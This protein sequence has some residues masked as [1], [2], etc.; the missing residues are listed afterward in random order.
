MD[1]VPAWGG[2]Y[3]FATNGGSRLFQCLPGNGKT[4]VFDATNKLNDLAQCC[5]MS[6]ACKQTFS[7]ARQCAQTGCINRCM[8]RRARNYMGCLI[9]Q[10]NANPPVCQFASLCVGQLTGNDS[11]DFAKT[12]AQDTNAVTAASCDPMDGF[13]DGLCDISNSCCP[14]CNT[15]MLRL[16][17]CLV[18]DFLLPASTTGGSVTCDLAL[19]FGQ[20]CQISGASGT[21]V[22]R[23]SGTFEETET[24]ETY[25][26]VEGVDISDCEEDLT[27]D[28]IVHNETYAADG[29][30]SCIGKKVGQVLSEAEGEN[31]DNPE[32]TSA[33]NSATF[34]LLCSVMVASSLWSMLA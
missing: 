26:D 28:F 13:V 34:V 24:E 19:P 17:D 32:P 4:K 9:R 8:K 18:N 25:T 33:A 5:E 27:L 21:S 6:D 2:K 7:D 12:L 16:V 30:I 15:P 22:A 10:V 23:T 20:P 31:V 14:S 3:D 11:F 1:P 29:F